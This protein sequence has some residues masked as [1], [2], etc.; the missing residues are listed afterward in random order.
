MKSAQGRPC[1]RGTL[2][3]KVVVSRTATGEPDETT[4]TGFPAAPPRSSS[5]QRSARP[6]SISRSMQCAVP[7]A[8]S[9]ACTNGSEPAPS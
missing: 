1:A 9:S 7:L 2:A 8:V 3:A 6:A 5:D 4:R